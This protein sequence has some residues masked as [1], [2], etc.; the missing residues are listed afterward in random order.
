MAPATRI[1]SAAAGRH[2]K[3][4]RLMVSHIIGRGFPVEQLLYD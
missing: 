4:V 3:S 1:E 2:S